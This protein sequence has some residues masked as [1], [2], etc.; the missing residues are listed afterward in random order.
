MVGFS[1]YLTITQIKIFLS[2]SNKTK[3]VSANTIRCL[4]LQ[5]KFQYIDIP[6]KPTKLIVNIPSLKQ[7]INIKQSFVKPTV[8]VSLSI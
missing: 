7:Y 4:I 1:T 2:S 8:N 5:I 6:S 3:Y